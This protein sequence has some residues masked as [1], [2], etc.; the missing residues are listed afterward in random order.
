MFGSEK[1][2]DR[3]TLK[4]DLG[5][6]AQF[7]GVI[8]V[9]LMFREKGTLPSMDDIGAK[10]KERFGD[11]DVVSDNL[12]MRM[13]ALKEYT[14]TVKNKKGEDAQMPA[15]LMMCGFNPVK[16]D[17]A[18]GLARSQFWDVEDG[19][20]LL[21]SCKWQVTVSDFLA[22]M[23]PDPKVRAGILIDWVELTLELFP[24]CVCIYFVTSGKLLTPDK[25]RNN[26][27]KG[28]SR[29]LY[30]GVNARFFNIEG[31]DEKVVDT[32]G[33]YAL[34]LPDVQYHFQGLDPDDVVNHAFNTV[35]YQFENDIPIESGNTLGGFEPDEK[36]KCQYENSLI[37]PVRVVLDVAAGENEAGNRGN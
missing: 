10:I 19:N 3:T 14:A 29:F 18:D 34:E 36:W 1:K 8:P 28:A 2:K 23:I 25:L 32:L 24:E 33:M 31:E 12:E 5:K 17:T 35:I 37:Q 21:D 27:L 13:W 6:K 20:E 16:N 4:Q 30:G 9:N 11:F 26:P 15:Q 22:A 7:S